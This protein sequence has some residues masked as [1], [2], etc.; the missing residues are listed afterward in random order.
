M[1]ASGTT[2]TFYDI[3]VQNSDVLLAVLP[4]VLVMEAE[5]V[6]NLVD[7]AAHAAT[8]C[9]ENGLLPANASQVRSAPDVMN[10]CVEEN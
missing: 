6:Q 4:R 2:F 10:G 3:M 1:Q 9:Q 5:G 8:G 7:D